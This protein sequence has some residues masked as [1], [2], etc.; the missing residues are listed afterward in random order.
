MVVHHINDNTNLLIPA[1]AYEFKNKACNQIAL[2]SVIRI[3]LVQADPC[4][5]TSRFQVI[6]E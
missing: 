5:L 2:N 6:K 3:R 4:T 1:L